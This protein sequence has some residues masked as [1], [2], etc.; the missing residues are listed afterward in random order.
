MI[1]RGVRVSNA[2]RNILL[3]SRGKVGRKILQ[4]SVWWKFWVSVDLLDGSDGWS[5]ECLTSLNRAKLNRSDF[6]IFSV[7]P[8]Q[9]LW[10]ASHHELTT[11]PH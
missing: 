2:V 4:V 6:V 10:P 7:P 9:F 8:Q 5:V 3:P 11:N 1:G